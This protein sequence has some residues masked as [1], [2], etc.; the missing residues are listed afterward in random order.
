M[1][2]A[3]IPIE[4]MATSACTI[5]TGAP[6]ADAA[7]RHMRSRNR[8]T[9]LQ[10]GS[11]LTCLAIPLQSAC[12]GAKFG[13]CDFPDSLRSKLLYE[14]SRVRLSMIQLPASWRGRPK[15]CADDGGGHDGGTAGQAAYP[16]SSA[17]CLN[18]SVP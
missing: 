3:P 12:C 7:L 13:V 5:L 17:A 1:R 15:G 16:L 2:A 9:I 4:W 6:E 11:A 10:V 8:G 14:S 18:R